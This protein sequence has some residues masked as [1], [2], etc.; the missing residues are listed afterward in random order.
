MVV[1]KEFINNILKNAPLRLY[2]ETGEYDYLI[3]AICCH[4]DSGMYL[5]CDGCRM[6]F[7]YFFVT[8][9]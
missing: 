1:L 3:M 6:E 9:H 7:K 8:D 5:A 2:C 4:G